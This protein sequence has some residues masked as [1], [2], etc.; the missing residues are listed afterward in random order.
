MEMRR[1]QTRKEFPDMGEF[2]KA[3]Q[4]WDL[5]LKYQIKI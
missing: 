2:K 4:K 1:L 5:P 3:V